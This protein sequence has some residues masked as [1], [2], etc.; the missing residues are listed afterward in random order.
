MCLNPLPHP[1]PSWGASL[2]QGEWPSGLCGSVCYLVLYMK[3]QTALE[4]QDLSRTYLAHC[5]LES[6]FSIIIVVIIIIIIIVNYQMSLMACCM[7]ACC[8]LVYS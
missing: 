4:R 7:D 6:E 3:C 1:L 5:E 2:T 8:T